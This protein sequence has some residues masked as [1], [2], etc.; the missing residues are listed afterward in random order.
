VVAE[1]TKSIGGHVVAPKPID[2]PVERDDPAGVQGE[3]RDEGALSRAAI[4]SDRVASRTSGG[5]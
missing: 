4:W 2:Q 1:G 5:T 3:Q